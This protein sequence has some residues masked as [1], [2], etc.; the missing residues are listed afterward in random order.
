MAQKGSRARSQ[1]AG[2][3]WN[4]HL[5]DAVAVQIANSF[6]FGSGGKGRRGETFQGKGRGPP[7]TGFPPR[8]EDNP[9]DWPCPCGL[10]VW[11]RKA[12]CPVCFQP[13]AKKVPE[14]KEQSTTQGSQPHPTQQAVGTEEDAAKVEE[15]KKR[16]QLKHIAKT[17]AGWPEDQKDSDIFRS[18]QKEAEDLKSA[19]VSSLPTDMQLLGAKE[20]VNA[21]RRRV[22]KSEKKRDQAIKD[23]TTAKDEVAASRA[24]ST[25][26]VERLE[27]LEKAIR[28]LSAGPQDDP[29]VTV[30]EQEMLKQLGPSGLGS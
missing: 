20:E 5:M 3:G 22:L 23:L 25:S 29:I 9:D 21:T 8:Q 12:A 17:L 7:T 24:S 18:I 19:L 14:I 26:A 1:S 10:K 6:Q 28:A 15:G 13:R 30:D 16:S 4:D 2:R 27:V 11:A